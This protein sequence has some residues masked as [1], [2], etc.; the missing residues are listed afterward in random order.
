MENGPREACASVARCHH[1]R[2]EARQIIRNQVTF[3]AKHHSKD[4]AWNVDQNYALAETEHVAGILH[5]FLKS[6]GRG[7]IIFFRSLFFC[8]LL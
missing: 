1:H 6:S 5:Q 7:F 3:C 2:V 8:L 4:F